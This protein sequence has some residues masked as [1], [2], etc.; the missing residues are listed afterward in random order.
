M[1]CKQCGKP[2]FRRRGNQE[3]CSPECRVKAQSKRYYHDKKEIKKRCIWCGRE[4]FTYRIAQKFCSE[5]CRVNSY[6]Q[7]QKNYREKNQSPFLKLRFQV[8]ERDDFKCRYCGRG[9]TDGVKLQI[10]HILAKKQNGQNEL[11]NYLTACE[12]CNLGKGDILLLANKNGQILSF[13][14]F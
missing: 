5:K 12:E 11:S 6:S 9:V 2:F 1:E 13:L 8:F 3:Y 14:N 7:A 10:D 4:Y